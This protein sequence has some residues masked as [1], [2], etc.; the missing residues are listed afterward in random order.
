MAAKRPPDGEYIISVIP[1]AA[2]DEF[3]ELVN[4]LA[5]QGDRWDTL[6]LFKSH[7]TAAAG[8]THWRSSALFFAEHDLRRDAKAA[9]QNAP[10]F[11]EAFFDG[12][13][14][15]EGEDEDRYAPDA[16]AINKLLS[17]HNIGFEIR[18]DRLVLLGEESELV[19]VDASTPT[20]A[21]RSEVLIQE[22]LNRA[23]ELLQQG[24][25]R[26]AVQESLWLLETVATAFKGLETR[27]GSI[28]GRYFNQIVRELRDAHRGG[29]LDRVLDWATSLHGY[30]SSPTG[31]GVRALTCERVCTFPTTR[32]GSSAI[33]Y[34]VM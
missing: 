24:N 17:R 19:D 14:G 1:D 15:F 30:L 7:F 11:I 23:S 13:R 4:K 9:A 22:A 2:V 20:L 10:L 16:V 12:C 8:A 26:E 25:G 29:V 5:P 3:V 21:E 18:G 31:G 27:K 33:S 34:G 32:P 6:E 28:E